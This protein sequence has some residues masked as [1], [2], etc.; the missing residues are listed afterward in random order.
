MN[1]LVCICVI[2]IVYQTTDLMMHCPSHLPKST[3]AEGFLSLG[4]KITNC[5]VRMSWY[6]NRVKSVVLGYFLAT[7]ISVPK[8]SPSKEVALCGVRRGSSS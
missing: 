1:S 5:D 3:K 8:S 6:G 2:Y 4:T 7:M